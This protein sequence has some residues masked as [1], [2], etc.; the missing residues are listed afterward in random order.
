MDILIDIQSSERDTPHIA[1]AF[2]LARSFAAHV[3]GLQVIAM[4]AMV[5]ALP[6]PLIVLENEENVAH[7]RHEWWDAACRRHGVAGSWEVQRG[8]HRRV[9]VRRASFAD[10]L[11]GRLPGSGSGIPLGT[12]LLARVLMTRVA[13]MV[14]VPDACSGALPRRLLLAWNGSAVAARA[15][16]AALPVLTRARHITLLAGDRA[17]RLRTGADALLRGWLE[18]HGIVCDWIELPAQVA[19]GEAICRYATEARADAIVMGAWGRSRLRELAL[20]GTTRHLLANASVPLFL[21]A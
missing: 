6:D 10:L 7:Q 2:A 20:G 15:I 12:G 9:L 19:A 13:P 14:L 1:F 3:T 17:G 11:V 16:R 4:D 18:R 8:V 5:V 21:S